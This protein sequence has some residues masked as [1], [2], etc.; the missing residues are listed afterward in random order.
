MMSG[1]PLIL[2]PATK[3]T[4][5]KIT[6]F[7]LQSA[8]KKNGQKSIIFTPITNDQQRHV[9]TFDEAEHLLLE[10]RFD[11]LLE[12]IATNYALE[13]ERQ[14]ADL[15]II[16]GIDL[17]CDRPYVALLNLAITK[18]LDAKVVFVANR[19]DTE[20]QIK[21]IENSYR[22][23]MPSREILGSIVHKVLQTIS[24]EDI[25]KIAKNIIASLEKLTERRVTPPVFCTNLIKCA[26]N[27]KKRIV[28][29][30]GD[31]PRTLKAA[32][33]ATRRGIAECILLGDGEKIRSDAAKLGV[34]LDGIRIVDTKLIS[35]RYIE[36]LVE[37]RKNKG[38]TPEKAMLELE[39]AVM[40]GTMMIQLNE[41]DGLVSG[42]I[43]TTANTVRPALQV[44]KTIP[45]SKIVSSVFFM[46]LPEEVL[47]YG[48]CAINPNP[49]AIDLADIAI[50]SADSA[51]AFGIPARVAMLSYSTGQ[52]GTGQDVDKIKLATSIVKQKRPDLEIEGPIQYDA[53][54]DLG[55]AKL[56]LPQSKVAGRATVFVF[57]DLN[58]GNIICKAVQRSTNIVC[59][60][61]MLQGLNKPVNDLSRGCSVED[62]VFT[63]AL[64]AAQA[65]N[66]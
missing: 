22:Q 8:L 18:T 52:S 4:D 28:L 57:P 32:E 2:I 54:V 3:N 49:T 47:V 33:I 45:G 50:Q 17:S 64:T 19:D 37:I 5:L 59:I 7:G 15:V 58:S 6:A 39:D 14:N 16:S 26:Q 48:D 21:I 23:N 31:E 43:H 38:M 42:A 36:P 66:N 56:K 34:V 27:A 12:N 61:P 30:E 29:P 53:A 60:G 24:S 1:Q 65:I 40:L 41:A 46:C 51:R 55:V 63:I 25:E 11:E 20:T 9:I 13:I 62:I 35:S 10:N 44:I